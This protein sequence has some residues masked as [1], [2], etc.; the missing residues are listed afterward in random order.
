MDTQRSRVRG[1][2]SNNAKHYQQDFNDIKKR[3]VG[4]DLPNELS[5]V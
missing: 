1:P 4:Q 5:R 3:Q 2:G